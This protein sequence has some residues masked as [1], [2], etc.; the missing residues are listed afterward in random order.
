MPTL[1]SPRNVP[2]RVELQGRIEG[3]FKGHSLTDNEEISPL[4]D[5][6]SMCDENVRELHEDDGDRSTMNEVEEEEENCS[7]QQQDEFDHNGIKVSGDE[8]DD[9]SLEGEH[10][11]EVEEEEMEGAN[12][13]DDDVNSS[14]NE[15]GREQQQHHI[16]NTGIKAVED[17]GDALPTFFLF[18]FFLAN[19]AGL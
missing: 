6:I 2:S 15:N 10:E 3:R 17:E 14:C 4:D 9:N 11:G 5:S 19:K 1:S 7:D 13:D 12:D 18:I 16:D 8:R